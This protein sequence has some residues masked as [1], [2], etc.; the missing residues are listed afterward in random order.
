MLLPAAVFARHVTQVCGVPSSY[1][2]TLLAVLLVMQDCG[3]QPA[4]ALVYSALLEHGPQMLQQ[5]RLV[6]APTVPQEHGLLNLG[7]HRPLN[8]R[9]VMQ[10]TSR[11]SQ[12]LLMCLNVLRAM[13]VYGQPA[14]H[15][16]VLVVKQVLGQHRQQPPVQMRVLHVLPVF[17]HR[18]WLLPLL[19]AAPLALPV[20]TRQQPGYH[21]V[22]SASRVQLANGPLQVCLRVMNVPLERGLLLP[23]QQIVHNVKYVPEEPGRLL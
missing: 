2:Q 17:G 14:L 4:L 20:H 13:Q 10:D 11:P 3:Q 7:H 15:H 22:T 12:G 18:W 23:A 5:H 21:Q 9:H 6:R 19:V 8:A 1:H 16:H